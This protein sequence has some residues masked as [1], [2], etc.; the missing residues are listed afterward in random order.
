MTK[1]KQTRLSMKLLWAFAVKFKATP[2]IK[3]YE[4]WISEFLH[5]VESEMKTGRELKERGV[6]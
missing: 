1:K 3:H 2:N 5:F 6:I 4:V